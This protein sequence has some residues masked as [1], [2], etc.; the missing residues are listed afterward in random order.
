M[1]NIDF[2]RPT[3]AQ[4]AVLTALRRS[5]TSGEL[6]PGSAIQQVA[7]AESMGVSRVP[8]REALKILEGEGHVVYEPHRGYSV[9]SLNASDLKEIYRLRELLETLAVKNAGSQF[10]DGLVKRMHELVLLMDGAIA[11]DDA[12]E[13]TEY[14]RQFHFALIEAS[15]KP[16]LIKMIFQLWD[17]SDAYRGVYFT[18]ED[19]RNEVQRE[20]RLMIDAVRQRNIDELIK[21]LDQHRNRACKSVSEQLE[22]RAN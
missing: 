17:A 2:V 3:T 15:Q 9:A 11:K 16:R 22:S 12:A 5:I 20:H 14:N 10:N 4:E 21:L 8:V 19:N 13:L 18:Q 7:V 6:A 1:S